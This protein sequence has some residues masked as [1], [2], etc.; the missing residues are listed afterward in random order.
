MF[1]E[2]DTMWRSLYVVL[3]FAPKNMPYFD[4]VSANCV[5]IKPVRFLRSF[6]AESRYALPL[7]CFKN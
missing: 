2:V 6:L 5:K 3:L 1:G 4:K 7:G